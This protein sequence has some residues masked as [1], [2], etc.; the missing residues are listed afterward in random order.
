MWYG[1]YESE[2]F[3]REK[4][5]LLFCFASKKGR[6]NT[7]HQFIQMTSSKQLGCPPILNDPDRKQNEFIE[8]G[9]RLYFSVNNQYSWYFHSK[10]KQ[11]HHLQP[12]SLYISTV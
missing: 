5:K 12:T 10:E 2:V 6:L 11:N 8:H 4:A 3:G 1:H 9:Y 7:K